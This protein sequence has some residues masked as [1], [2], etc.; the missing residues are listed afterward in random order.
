M[1]NR[2]VDIYVPVGDVHVTVDGPGNT[3]VNT[4]WV[5]V[6]APKGKWMMACQW[7]EG[8]TR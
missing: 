3:V 5:N 4:P 6:V 8:R 7:C 2:Q 1:Y